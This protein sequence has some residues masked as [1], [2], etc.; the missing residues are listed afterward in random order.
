MKVC[1]VEIK[2]NEVILCALENQQ[3]LF[4]VIS[5]RKP[6]LTVQDPM[7]G[8][9]L[10]AFQFEFAKLMQDYQISQVV[11]KSR[12]SKGKF[13]GGVPGFKME[14]AI[15]LIDELTTEF[16]NTNDIKTKLKRTPLP[17]TCVDLGLKKFQLT[18]LESAFSYLN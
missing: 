17:A 12:P 18:A 3:G 9:Q 1:G 4:N 14:A 8:E 2:G 11:I 16:I 7:D 5:L 10:K 6:R 15:Q 13:A